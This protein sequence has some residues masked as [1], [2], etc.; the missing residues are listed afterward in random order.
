MPTFTNDSE[1]LEFALLALRN[2]ASLGDDG[3]LGDGSTRAEMTKIAQATVLAIEKSQQ[4]PSVDLND[5]LLELH[6]ER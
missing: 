3:H 1:R 2:I 5:F 4:A 6:E